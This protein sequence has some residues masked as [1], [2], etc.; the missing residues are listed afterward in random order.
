[1]TIGKLDSLGSAIWRLES[2]LD[3][4]A[5]LSDLKRTIREALEELYEVRN[6]RNSK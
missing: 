4:P 1:M 3:A 5:K 2:I 6:E